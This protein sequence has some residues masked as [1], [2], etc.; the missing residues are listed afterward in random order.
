MTTSWLIVY[1]DVDDY[2]EMFGINACRT[3]L[4]RVMIPWILLN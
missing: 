3:D 4:R 2:D 1:D